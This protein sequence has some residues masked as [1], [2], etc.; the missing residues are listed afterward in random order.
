MDYHLPLRMSTL[1]FPPKPDDYYHVASQKCSKARYFERKVRK[2]EEMV[3]G[4]G[5]G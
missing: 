3:Q 5:Q 4:K 1:T 2:E